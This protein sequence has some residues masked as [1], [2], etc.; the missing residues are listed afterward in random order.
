MSLRKAVN[1]Y[2][3]DCV[4]D[5]LDYGSAAQQIAC[6]TALTCKLH[7]KRPVTA[8]KIPTELLDR[9]GL[10]PADLCSRARVLVVPRKKSLG[11]TENESLA[12]T[13]LKPDRGMDE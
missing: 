13:E 1:D 12:K 7:P 4:Y 5:P 2:C 10:S 9:F 3:R 8:S 6:C 11:E